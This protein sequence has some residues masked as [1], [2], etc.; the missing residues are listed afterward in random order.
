MAGTNVKTDLDRIEERRR[1]DE[2]T[3]AGQLALELMHEIKNPLDA[4][5]NLTYLT[6]EEAE[7]PELV[8]SY[9]KLAEEQISTLNRLSSPDPRNSEGF[10]H[11]KTRGSARAD[12]ISSSSTSAKT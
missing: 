2:L 8:R 12:R 4:L 1:L 6:L 10:W 3:V 11:A 5:G 7:N 9:M